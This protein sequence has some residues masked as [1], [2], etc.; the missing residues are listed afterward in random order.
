MIIGL[1]TA[2]IKNSTFK[3]CNNPR[4]E[5][6]QWNQNPVEPDQIKFEGQEK[7]IILPPIYDLVLVVV[8]GFIGSTIREITRQPPENFWRFLARLASPI[9]L[10]VD[11]AISL[12]VFGCVFLL[13]I[14]MKRSLLEIGGD[15]L[16][17]YN[18][19]SAALVQFLDFW[20]SAH[21]SR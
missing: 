1:R 13:T 18:V 12:I 7:P 15:A 6:I 14:L 5:L 19:A 17:I 2:N 4:G 16:L 21:F 3:A 8:F 11:P 20:E 10:F 9:S